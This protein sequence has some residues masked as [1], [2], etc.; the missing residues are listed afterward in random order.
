M[1]QLE[2]YDKPFAQESKKEHVV[3]WH[4]SLGIIIAICLAG[5]TAFADG[6]PLSLGVRAVDYVPTDGSSAWQGGIQARLRLPLFF[7]VEASADHRRDA[8]GAT[9]AKDYPVQVSA[10][11]YVLPKIVWVQPF[12]LAGGGWYHTDVDGPA[13]FSGHQNRF[14]PHVGAGLE[15][16]VT[17]NFFIDGTYRFVWLNDLHSVDSQGNPVSYRDRG[18][19]ITVGLNYKL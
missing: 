5:P 4:V 10:L 13:N 19:M 8:F 11:L 7:A 15:F 12:V 2:T 6:G 18:H 17:S 16:N 3:F 14:G 1:R 9:T